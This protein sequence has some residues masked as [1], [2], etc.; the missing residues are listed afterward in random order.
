MTDSYQELL[1]MCCTRGKLEE[2]KQA[3][4]AYLADKVYCNVNTFLMLALDNNNLD[5]ADF[6]VKFCDNNNYEYMQSEAYVRMFDVR[7]V[8]DEPIKYFIGL[9]K[10]KN[11]NIDNDTVDYVFKYWRMSAFLL[12][13]DAFKPK[14]TE[15]HADIALWECHFEKFKF[16]LSHCDDHL[17]GYMGDRPGVNDAIIDDYVRRRGEKRKLVRWEWNSTYLLKQCFAQ[18]FIPREPGVREFVLKRFIELGVNHD[19]PRI[20]VDLQRQIISLI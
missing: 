8:T 13:Y 6:I 18:G 2:F 11:V 1:K 15:H 12:F 19:K 4:P 14:I 20:P 9:L 7:P 3:L 17:V 16:A 10:K 5:V